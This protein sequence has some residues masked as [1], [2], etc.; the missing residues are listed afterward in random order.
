[1]RHLTSVINNKSQNPTSRQA[2][3]SSSQFYQSFYKSSKGI[4][5]VGFW[6]F[7]SLRLTDLFYLSILLLFV[8]S[9]VVLSFSLYFRLVAFLYNH[10]VIRQNGAG[11]YST[12]LWRLILKFRF[13]PE[14]LPKRVP[15]S[16]KHTHYRPTIPSLSCMH[17][18]WP[19]WFSFRGTRL[20]DSHSEGWSNVN[21]SYVDKTSW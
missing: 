10:Q 13:R 2:T 1:M 16:H 19:I 6:C 14:K 17:Y 20:T 12:I 21:N 5:V 18:C 4:Y 3:A 8:M 9:Y 11:S 15:D 7:P